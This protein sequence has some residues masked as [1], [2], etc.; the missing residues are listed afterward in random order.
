MPDANRT[1]KYA[2]TYARTPG[3]AADLPAGGDE[4]LRWV[5]NT[6]TLIYGERDAVLIDT[7]TTIEQN[8]ALIEW[9]KAFDRTLTH[10]YLTHGHGD[11]IF[12]IKQIRDAFP[13]T[14][15]IAT[16]GTVAA[17][18]EQAGAEMMATV[19][20]P[21]FPG[22]IAQPPAFPD[23][24]EGS[25]IELEGHLI[26]FI[27]TGFTDTHDTTAVWVPDIGVLVAGDAAYNEIHMWTAETSE[28]TRQD[29]VRVI[30][31]L[32]DL[33][34]THV[35]AGHKHPDLDDDPQI[36]EQSRRYLIDFDRTATQVSSS[37]DLYEQMLGL[38]PDRLN[39]A[40]L[41][42]GANAAKASTGR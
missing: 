27:A 16:P 13:D 38:Y 34:A 28:S 26:D 2:T 3:I 35:V 7:F 14:Q 6:A 22:Q 9:V 10:L 36:L 12:G 31:R 18:H 37:H 39:P 23:S 42:L 33:K 25:S 15:I 29:W 20:N 21:M 30:E 19:W 11:H 5:S 32:A 8:D 40:A 4:T 1:L 24:F 41:W 17:S